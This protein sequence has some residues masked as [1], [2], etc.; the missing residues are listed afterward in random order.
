MSG[1]TTESVLGSA[2]D[3]LSFIGEFSCVPEGARARADVTDEEL[4]SML[5]H[6]ANGYKILGRMIGESL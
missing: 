1:P 3:R 2:G 6:F 4:Y 5:L